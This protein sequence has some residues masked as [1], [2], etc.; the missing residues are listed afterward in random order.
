[1]EQAGADRRGETVAEFRRLNVAASAIPRRP[2][3]GEAAGGGDDRGRVG[4]R[5]SALCRGA[6]PAWLRTGHLAATD[7][8]IE[9]IDGGEPKDALL[10]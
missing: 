2:G 9:I 4:Q 1:M 8:P 10:T 6:A 5:P 7:E 3:C